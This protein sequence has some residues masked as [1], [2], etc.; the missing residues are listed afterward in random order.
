MIFKGYVLL[1][2]NL[3]GLLWTVNVD[4]KK[5]L[6]VLEALFTVKKEATIL[7]KVD[8]QERDLNEETDQLTFSREEFFERPDAYDAHVN[9]CLIFILLLFL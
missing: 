1:V 9:A 4:A 3:L 2:L 7:K 6:S 5:K 8:F